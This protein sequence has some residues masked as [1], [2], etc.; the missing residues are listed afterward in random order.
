M[1][2]ITI[3]SIFTI[4]IIAYVLGLD[5]WISWLGR[6][7]HLLDKFDHPSIY[8]F[9]Y[10]TEFKWWRMNPLYWL[11]TWMDWRSLINRLER[12]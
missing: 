9:V 12:P 5:A 11:F 2:I 8:R 6:A 4:C 7:Q 3:V 1:T 10:D